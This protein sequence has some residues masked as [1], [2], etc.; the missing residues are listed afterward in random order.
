MYMDVAWCEPTD[1]MATTLVSSSSSRLYCILKN[2]ILYYLLKV[3]SHPKWQELQTLIC[4]GSSEAFFEPEA[5]PF[6]K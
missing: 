3:T 5:V 1:I 4:T 6:A 2:S